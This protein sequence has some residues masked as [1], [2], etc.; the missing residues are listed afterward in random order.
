[1]RTWQ[2]LGSGDKGFLVFGVAAL[3]VFALLA[4]DVGMRGRLEQLDAPTGDWLYAH[5]SSL[6]IF[7]NG[8][9][10]LGSIVVMGPVVALGAAYLWWRSERREAVR[11]AVI[12][13]LG[14]VAYNGFKLVF[15][16]ARPATA[17]GIE[18]GYSFPS[19]HTTMAAVLM[20]YLAWLGLRRARGKALTALLLVAVIAWALLMALS[21]LTLGVHY[22]T[23]VLAGL[24][25]GAGIG[26]LGVSLPALWMGPASSDVAQEVS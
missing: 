8:M 10:L 13:G 18:T 26:A 3:L 6:S 24:A 15:A 7:S 16:R 4:A 5:A 14:L 21:R 12:V 9:D 23:D 19:G 20:V 2:Q 11:L 25:L 22:L 17:L 1:M